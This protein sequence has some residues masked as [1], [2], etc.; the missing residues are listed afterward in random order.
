[1]GLVLH[2]QRWLPELAPRLHVAVPVPVRVGLPAPELGYDFPWSIVPWFRGESAADVEPAARAGAAAAL[3]A[4]VTDLG[5]PA[6]ADAPANPFRGVPLADRD[7]VIRARLAGG[8]VPGA[9][10]LVPVWERA[11][12]A[13][14]WAGPKV[15]LHGDLHPGNLL[16]DA[17]GALA[18]VVD[19][20][21]VTA[22]DP[23]TDLAT[24]WLTFEPP[25][26]RV[27]RAEVERVRGM[28][29]AMWDRARGW[30]LA[31]GTIVDSIGTSGRIGR[32]GAHALE[33]VLAD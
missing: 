16:L 18:A 10:R 24:A 23:A 14:V 25:A 26:R 13:S 9:A 20:G 7:E 27:F 5:V 28:D 3:A 8:R 21:D 29:D 4:F 15:W 33:Q 30:A 11:L 22:G 31:F 6:P 32:V 2:E 19:F 12:E 1:M 17:S